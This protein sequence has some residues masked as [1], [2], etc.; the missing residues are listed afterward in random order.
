MRYL[1]DIPVLNEPSAVALGLFDGVHRGHR[2]VI[3]KAVSCAPALT[4]VVFT[5][6]FDDPDQ[7][8]KP[9]YAAILSDT[10]KREIFASLGVQ[11]VVEPPFSSFRELSPEDFF[12]RILREKL[13]AKAVFCGGDYRFGKNAAWGTGELIRLGQSHG[14]RVVCIPPVQL[15]G[16]RVSSRRI[17]QLLAD[18]HPEAA[19]RLLGGDYRIG[20]IVEHGN[21]LGRTM[22]FPTLNQFFTPGQCTPRF[23]VY[24]SAAYPEGSPVPA[25]TNIGMRPTI[26]DTSCPIGET[27]ILDWEGTLYGRDIP[28]ALKAFLRPEQR[29][30]GIAAL[31]R[32][33]ARDIAAARDYG[34]KHQQEEQQ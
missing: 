23:G 29:F 2:A 1:K 11:A 10:R 5:F 20:G 7:I 12:Q 4:P 13:N 28:V 6:T 27:Y 15:E 22:G 21:Q 14:Y 33:L 34:A 31:S 18:G 8:T 25:V 16:E 9:H 19:A 32:Q 30:D 24:A 17:R 26:G 3:E